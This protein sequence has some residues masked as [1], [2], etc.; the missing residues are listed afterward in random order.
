[1][2]KCSASIVPIQKGDEFSLMQYPNNELEWNQM[3]T[4]HY[5]SIV[6]NLMHTRTCTRPYISFVVGM[7]GRYENNPWMNH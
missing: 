2:D 1:M 6:E 5:A 3:E 7:L 4:I